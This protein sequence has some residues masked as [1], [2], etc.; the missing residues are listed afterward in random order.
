VGRFRA[1]N[2]GTTGNDKRRLADTVIQPSSSQ[3]DVWATFRL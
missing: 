1:V 3:F 2:C